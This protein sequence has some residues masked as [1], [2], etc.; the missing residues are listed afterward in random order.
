MEAMDNA[1]EMLNKSQ[2]LALKLTTDTIS[3]IVSMG[4]TGL[5]Q[6]EE[7]LTQVTTLLGAVGD[8]AGATA[9]PLQTFITRQRELAD[10]MASLA[11]AQADLAELVNVVAQ[12]HADIVESLESVTAPLFGLVVKEP[13]APPAP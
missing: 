10:T 12:R 5:T 1:F 13:P 7:L 4:R 3:T 11:Q 8:L 6:P 2:R 9:Q